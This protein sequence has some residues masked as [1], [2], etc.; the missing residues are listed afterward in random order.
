MCY[1]IDF[2]ADNAECFFIDKTTEQGNAVGKSRQIDE[3]TDKLFDKMLLSQ[4]ISI[5]GST[6]ISY[7]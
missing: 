2:Q 1:L 6:S 7:T 4:H 5:K 3:K